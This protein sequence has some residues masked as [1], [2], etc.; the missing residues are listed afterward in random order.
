MGTRYGR[1]AS[2]GTTEYYDSR[3]QLHE[4]AGHEFEAQLT[5]WFGVAGL[6]LGAYVAYALLG[7]FADSLPKIIRFSLVVAAACGCAYLLARLAT[8]IFSI[9]MLLLGLLMLAGIGTIVWKIV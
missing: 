7:H 3:E 8:I 1:K 2:D 9:A 4:A 5:I 6:L